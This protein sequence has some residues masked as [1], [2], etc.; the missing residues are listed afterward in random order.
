MCIE[1]GASVIVAQGAEAGGHGM[2]SLQARATL[3]L[4]PELA[5][6]LAQHSPSALL[7]AAGGIADGRSG[8]A[9]LNRPD[10]CIIGVFRYGKGAGAGGHHEQ[11]I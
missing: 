1:A 3:S 8:S 10:K 9:K 5:D 11:I 2:H 7:V 6:A 4:V